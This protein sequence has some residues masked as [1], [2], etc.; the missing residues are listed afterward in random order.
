MKTREKIALVKELV[1]QYNKL[2][3]SQDIFEKVVGQIDTD[4]PLFG[5]VWKCFE[6]YT[7]AVGISIGDVGEYLPWF[8]WDNRCGANGHEVTKDGKVIAI[9][10]VKDLIRLM[11]S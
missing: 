4:G 1:R 11:E 8:I 9:K 5:P 3:K 6:A 10:S 7:E 2:S